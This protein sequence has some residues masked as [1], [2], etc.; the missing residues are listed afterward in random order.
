[1]ELLEGNPMYIIFTRTFWKSNKSWPK[2]LEP[3]LGRKTRID[4]CHSEEQAQTICREWNA[5][6]EAGRFSRKAEYMNG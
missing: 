5:T 3:H 6:N 1:M 2:G 4:T